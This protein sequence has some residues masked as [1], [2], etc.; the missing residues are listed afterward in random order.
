MKNRYIK[1]PYEKEYITSVEDKKNINNITYCRPEESIIFL[2]SS[3]IHG[4]K[5]TIN[6]EKPKIIEGNNS[7]YFSCDSESM[8]MAID[9]DRRLDIM[10][11]NLGNAIARL[12]IK[13]STSLN[14]EDYKIDEISNRIYLLE[15]DISFNTINQLEDLANYMINANLLVNIFEGY[16]EL[17]GMGSIDYSGPCLKRTGEISILKIS[18]I[19]KIDG[20][21]VL[22][23]SCGIRGFKNYREKF[24][25]IDNIKNILFLN[26]DEDILK[27]IKSL[28]SKGDNLKEENKRMEKELG[29]ETVKEYKKLATTVDGINYIYKV[30]RNVN[31][32]DI[33]FISN[34]IMDD[35]NFVQIYGIPNG[36][37]SQVLVARSKNLNIDL[38]AIFDKLSTKFS[39]NGT[40][41]MFTIQANVKSEQLAGV[42]E[43][44]LIEIK[45][46]NP[47]IK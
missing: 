30:V 24:T 20:K 18:N 46:S 14:V 11:Q 15:K 19:E 25:L 5:Y 36:P 27:E 26:S 9:Y 1:Y 44:F 33:K 39:V 40:G 7:T 41:N 37:M 16:I 2:G 42:M 43:S 31:F 3:H 34:Y 21:V 35:Y 12:C 38:K 10:Q 29:L 47:L 45:K 6:S 22:S 13:T 32:K 17:K 23:I 28:K 4:D 8:K